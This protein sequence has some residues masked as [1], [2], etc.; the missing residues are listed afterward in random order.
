MGSAREFAMV[1]RLVAEGLNDC[2][3]SR[4][5]GIPRTTVRTGDRTASRSESCGWLPETPP[6]RLS[7]G[8]RGPT[9]TYSA[10]T[11]ETAASRSTLAPSSPPDHARF[12]LPDDHL[13]VQG[14]DG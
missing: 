4:R 5:T 11:S 6:A 2:D 1:E 7:P 13:G 8:F 10:S 9:P 3:V 14:D 12:G